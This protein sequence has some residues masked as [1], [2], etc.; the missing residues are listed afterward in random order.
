MTTRFRIREPG[1]PPRVVRLCSPARDLIARKGQEQ[2]LLAVVQSL[3]RQGLLSEAE[4]VSNY[5]L[6]EGTEILDCEVEEP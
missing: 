2:A 3:N 6:T 5:P 4:G 1:E